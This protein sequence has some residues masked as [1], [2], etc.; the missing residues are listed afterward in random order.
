MLPYFIK[1]ENISSVP[2]LRHYADHGVSGYQHVEYFAKETRKPVVKI[3]KL[4]YESVAETGVP[5]VDDIG[6]IPVNG[7]G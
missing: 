2:R 4:I 3:K 6:T 5:H 7:I 1:L